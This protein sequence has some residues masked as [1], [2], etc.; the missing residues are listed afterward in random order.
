MRVPVEKIRA[1]ILHPEREVRN[2]TVYYFARSRSPDPTIMPL[3]IE[4]IARFGLEA[5]ISYSFL[6]H[7]VQTEQS[8]KW[9]LQEIERIGR[10]DEGREA[11]YLQSLLQGLAHADPTLLKEHKSEIQVTKEIDDAVRE[12]VKFRINLSTLDPVALWRAFNDF[13]DEQEAKEETSNEDY[14]RGCSI[15]EVMSRFPDHFREQ[16]LTILAEDSEEVRTVLAV[17]LAGRMRLDAAVPE[18]L[19]LVEGDDDW[20]NEEIYWALATIGSDAVVKEIA[21]RYHEVDAGLRSAYASTLEE[22]RTDLSVETCLKLFQEEQDEEIRGRLLQAAL[23]NFAPAAVEPARQYVLH[24]P[25]TPDVLEVRDALLVVCKVMETTFPEFDAWQEDRKNDIAFRQEWYKDHP[26]V[27]LAD[28]DENDIQDGE[29]IFDDYE[30]DEESTTVVR[31][32]PSVGRND[33]C[34]CGSGKKYKKCCYGK[35]GFEESDLADS[36]GM[37]EA[38]PNASAVSYP[39]ATVAYYGPDDRVTTKIVVGVFP[40]V[41]AE[42]ILERWVGTNVTNNP[43]VKRQIKDF[44]DKRHVKNVVTSDGNLG[45][46]HEEGQDFPQGEDCPFCPFWAGKQ[47]SNR[48]G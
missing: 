45:C 41:G 21:A 1:A 13:C 3:V 12:A 42:A 32:S 47:G 34:P 24:T 11:S 48:Q 44:L 29:D 25:K 7:L 26:L 27:E 17:R 9:M 14:E 46:P 31:R 23:M 8:L 37:S 28:H 30:D 35:D 43:K 5:F 40:R 15:V 36:T 10:A 6:D 38:R 2:D 20:L 22:I 4:A 39:L 19:D 16:T 18:L 33:P